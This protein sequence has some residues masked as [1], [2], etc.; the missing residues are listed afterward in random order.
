MCLACSRRKHNPN[1]KHGMSRVGQKTA[2]YQIWKDMKR[3]CASPRKKCFKDYGG[4]GIYVCREWLSDFPQFL[5]DMGP[6]PSPEMTLERIDNDGPYCKANC[7]WATRQEQNQNK[8]NVKRHLYKGQMLTL[9][10]LADLSG[11]KYGTLHTRIDA[12]GM[13]LE[14]AVDTPL[15]PSKWH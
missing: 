12:L 7:R 13:P 15:R 8:R 3:R 1:L 4:R 6:R 10:Q 11:L 14:Q 2:E 9:R 5:S